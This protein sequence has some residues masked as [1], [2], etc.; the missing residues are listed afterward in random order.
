M[1]S[2]QGLSRGRYF[3]LMALSATEILGT[4]P[5]GTYIIVVS[6]K[7]GV[8]PWKGWAYTH[9][10]YSAVAQIAGFIWRNDYNL[11]SGLEMFR[12]SLVA[13][14]FVFFAFFGFTNETRQLYRRVY[15]PI[16][17]RIGVPRFIFH[18]PVYLCV[19]HSL[20]ESLSTHC[21]SLISLAVLR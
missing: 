2:S 8:G 13:C 12:W 16:F 1:M 4:I 17:S 3:R 6:A 15:T 19:V 14:A 5:L 9:S 7:A 10:N 21:G 11:N 18:G 20:S